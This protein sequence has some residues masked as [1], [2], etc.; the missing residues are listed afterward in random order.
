MGHRA[1]LMGH[2]AH[3]HLGP[4]SGAPLPPKHKREGGQ[5]QHQQGE[6]ARHPIH[7]ALNRCLAG[8]GLLHQLDDAGDG[9][10]IAAAVH[11]KPQGGLEIEAARRQ[12]RARLGLQG[13]G[14]PGETRHIHRGGPLKHH[15][16]HGHP[17]ARQ[18]LH[19]I[20]GPQSPHAHLAGL[21]IP[22]QQQGRIRLEGSELLQRP[23]GAK[24]G[25]LLQEAAQQHKAKQQH[26]FVEKAGPAGLGPQKSHQ[27]G[28]IGTGHAQAHQGVHRRQPGQGRLGAAHQDHP[29]RTSEGQRG[30]QGMKP[31]IGQQ[32]GHHRPG[33][34]PHQGQMAQARHQQQRQR[35]HQLAPLLPPV[36]VLQPLPP[37]RDLQACLT[38][39]G[40]KAQARQGLLQSRQ[41]IGHTGRPKGR[42]QLHP[43][44]A[45]EQV[46][47]GLL[48]ARL[49][50]Q[51]LLHGPHTA[52]ALH[53]LDLQQEGLKRHR[54]RDQTIRRRALHSGQIERSQSS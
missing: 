48:H 50:Q 51:A 6:T 53:P 27:A 30:H 25:P 45:G 19:H 32:A 8:L 18:H 47:T 34:G 46:D 31:L 39:A 1:H 52:A 13:Q 4:E 20:A 54:L 10:V 41:R 49:L 11:L 7:Q 28:E 21:A 37:R 43:G 12:F 35:H 22:H 36:L 44:R 3:Q 42:I 29:A 38:A 17:I 16:I 23:P 15:A 5:P 26:R 2:L 24:P 40:L 9:A 14:F 33:N